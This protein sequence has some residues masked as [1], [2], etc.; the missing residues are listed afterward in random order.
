MEQLPK[1]WPLVEPIIAPLLGDDDDAALWPLALDTIYADAQAL[2]R[3]ASGSQRVLT[4]IGRCSHWMAP[5]QC[6]WTAN[7]GFAWPSGYGAA[8]FCLACLPEFDWLGSWTWC[9]RSETW[10]AME[11]Q[12]SSRD[13]V[14]RVA[15]PSRTRL[16]HQAAVHTIWRPGAPPLPRVEVTQF[17]GFRRHMTTWS[18]TAYRYWSRHR[19]ARL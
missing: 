9:R 8:T 6:R 3:L 12:P 17:Y 4:Q 19:S 5:N 7:G 2:I 14:F 1:F 10:I 11:G 18:C 15:V 13:L 16:H